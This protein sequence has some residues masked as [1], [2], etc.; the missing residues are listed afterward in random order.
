MANESPIRKIRC[1]HC[2][3]EIAVSNESG[4]EICPFCGNSVPYDFKSQR[5]ENKNVSYVD[6][7]TGIL[8]GSG[9][10]DPKS[11]IIFLEDYLE[12]HKDTVEK[13]Y[14]TIGVEEIKKVVD[15][16]KLS[17]GGEKETWELDFLSVCAPAELRL[18]AILNEQ[19][20]MFELIEDGGSREQVYSKFDLIVEAMKGSADIKERVESLR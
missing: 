15:E 5:E 19:Q 1:P 4:T 9:N 17:H 10:K 18:D 11:V 6:N 12:K 8:I 7:S 20:E 14:N 3:W 2:T 13:I 16:I